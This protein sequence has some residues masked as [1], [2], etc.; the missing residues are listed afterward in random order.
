MTR[1][2]LTDGNIDFAIAYQNSILTHFDNPVLETKKSQ[3]AL[4]YRQALQ[5]AVSNYCQLQELML[6]KP[7]PPR[8]TCKDKSG[9][10]QDNS[11]FIEPSP[12]SLIIEEDIAQSFGR[13]GR[14]A[15]T[16]V[17]EALQVVNSL[18]RP[19]QAERIY[20]RGEHRYGY[21]LK[22][23]A[24]RTMEVE[25]GES[26][27]NASGITEREIKELRRFQDDVKKDPIF[28]S[29]IIGSDRLP[30]DDDPEWLPIMQHYDEK[31]GTRLLDIT[32]S[33]Y[34]ALHFACIDWN[35]NIDFE[36]D[37][38]LYIIFGHGRYYKYELT[39]DFDDEISEFVP[40]KVSDAFK[41]WKHPEFTHHFRS[42]QYSR[43]EM[44]QDGFFL[45]QG[46]IGAKPSFGG[47]AHFKICI[48][49]WAKARIIEELW[50][51]GYT[52]ERI[53]RGSKGETAAKQAKAAVDEYRATNP[54]WKIPYSKQVIVAIQKVAHYAMEYKKDPNSQSAPLLSLKGIL[55]HQLNMS[56]SRIAAFT[57]GLDSLPVSD[58][59]PQDIELLIGQFI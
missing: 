10:S 33:I 49:W 54:G 55:E 51:A 1:P 7:I 14:G 45:V 16:T 21:A 15:V 23:R 27:Q 6:T 50:F 58:T 35:G 26:L 44:A 32:S 25:T 9:Q 29:E 42:N 8:E 20:Y 18:A 53:I 48:P 56:Q 2:W 22:S 46:D 24:Q 41:N 17:A 5:S 31:F 19:H 34:T 59:N 37:G 13:A 12:Y 30:D 38:L 52:P 39:G 43:R 4:V 40:K 57:K 28:Q 47:K 36:T 3:E 11:S